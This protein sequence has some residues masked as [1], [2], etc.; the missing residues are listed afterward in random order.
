MIDVKVPVNRD[1]DWKVFVENGGFRYE[2]IADF[3]KYLEDD[4]D[5][6][7]TDVSSGFCDQDD[8]VYIMMRDG[9]STIM[10]CD[11]EGNLIERIPIGKYVQTP[12]FGC[13]TPEGN[14]LI[15]NAFMHCAV[16]MTQDG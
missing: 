10:K 14:M 3:P 1:K 11:V 15:T 7:F 6:Q 4:P 5:I 8:I 9:R 13:I 12:H 2:F 16:E